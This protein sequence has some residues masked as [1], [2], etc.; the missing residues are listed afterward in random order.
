MSK[1]AKVTA[2]GA[3]RYGLPEGAKVEH[4]GVQESTSPDL[5]G[6]KFLRKV[7]FQGRRVGDWIALGGS[8]PSATLND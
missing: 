6:I 2:E 7:T 3:K 8:D 4:E 1:K 5:R